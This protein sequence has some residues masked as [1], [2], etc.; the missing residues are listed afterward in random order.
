M[1]KASQ[2]VVPNHSG[3]WIVRKSGASRASRVFVTR[4]DAVAYARHLARKDRS[5]VYIHGRDGTV[6]QRDSY[7]PDQSPPRN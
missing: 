6:S 7:G 2:H 5:E 4:N 3:R 1:N